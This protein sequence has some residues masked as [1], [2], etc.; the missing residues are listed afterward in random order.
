MSMQILLAGDAAGAL[1]ALAQELKRA[2][3]SVAVAA[4]GTQALARVAA[5]TP[6]LVV[7]DAGL[8]GPSGL[9]VLRRISREHA[10]PVVLLTARRAE[11]DV[12][13][14]YELG[15]DD[16][17]AASANPR[18]VAGRVAAILRRVTERRD[19]AGDEHPRAGRLGVDP[20]VAEAY[21]D[22]VPV[23]LTPLEA[24]LLHLLVANAGRTVPYGTLLE[25]GWRGEPASRAN[26]KIR[27]HSLRRK[28]ADAD[29]GA[30]AIRTVIGTGYRLEVQPESSGD[31]PSA[32][33]TG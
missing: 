18:L 22:G 32:D 33:A 14:A 29:P 15:A 7:L 3:H 17:I 21:L 27:V 2:G 16:V 23:R 5:A 30:V 24:R 10:V 12:L 25:R 28:L 4:D 31:G 13:H 8:P 1:G 6:D 20:W 9:E 19:R 11:E 26:L